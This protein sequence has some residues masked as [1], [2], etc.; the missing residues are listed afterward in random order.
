MVGHNRRLVRPGPARSTLGYATDPKD[1]KWN[2]NSIP[3]LNNHS[4]YYPPLIDIYFDFDHSDST[5]NKDSELEIV[6]KSEF[7]LV[8]ITQSC[9]N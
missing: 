4:K 3:I 5:E 1:V 8:H 2:Q 7:Q 6:D 9:N